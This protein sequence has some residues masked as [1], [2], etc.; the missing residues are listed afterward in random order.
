MK[1]RL[2][3]FL[4]AATVALGLSGVAYAQAQLRIVGSSTVYPF[5]SYIAGSLGA[6]TDYQTPVIEHTGTGGGMQLFCPGTD[7][8]TPDIV[9]ASRRITV[10]EFKRCRKNGVDQITEIV[11][12]YDGIVFA[13][14]DKNPEINLTRKQITLALAARVPRNGELVPNPYTN[15]NQI[16]PSLPDREILVY[17]PPTTS[18]TRDAFEELAMAY[19]SRHIE[20][21]DGAYTMIR[22]DGIYVPAG[23]NDNLLVQRIAQN[24]EAFAIFGWSYL[25][26][27]RS[28]IQA[29]SIDGVEPRRGLISSG[30]Y[31]VAR[32]LYFYTKN[33]HID[34]VAAMEPYID[35]FLSEKMIGDNGYLKNLGL[36]PLPEPKRE[37]MRARW[38][39]R[40][41]LQLSDL[42][43]AK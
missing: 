21:Y 16:D 31:P 3:Y 43:Q 2:V 22:R 20:G 37:A 7:S 1:T 39:A 11:F 28:I 34:D 15:W 33:S 26:E 40:K 25:E 36:I 30:R 27:N 18:G 24:P 6:T 41:T 14:S 35:L 17:G 8:D 32:S 4:A 42:K 38:D 12:G 9:N 19:G 13:Q 5:S 29:A 23:E 10:A